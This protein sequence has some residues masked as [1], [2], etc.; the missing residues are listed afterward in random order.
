MKKIVESNFGIL[1]MTIIPTIITYTSFMNHIEN[2]II[3]I[4]PHIPFI[5]AI[6]VFLFTFLILHIRKWILTYTRN[7]E[8]EIKS[9]KNN[10]Y[11]HAQHIMYI[12]HFYSKDEKRRNDK[13]NPVFIDT[14]ELIGVLQSLPNK[15]I[16]NTKK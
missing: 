13:I 15:N 4:K 14:N 8:N 1:I 7:I 16:E 10:N 5:S 6:I 12:K 3:D 2:I 9:L 11:N